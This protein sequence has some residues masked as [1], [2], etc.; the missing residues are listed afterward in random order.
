MAVKDVLSSEQLKNYYDAADN[1]SLIPGW[2]GGGHD[3]PPEIE[4]YLWRWSEVEP[5]VLKSG[6]V[7]TPDRDVERRTMRLATPGLQRGTTHTLVAALQLLLPGECAP[8][9]RHTPT[10]IRWILTGEGAYTT[11]EG[12]KCVREP[13]DLILTPSWTWHDHTDDGNSPMI[14]LDGLDV[15]LVQYLKAAFWEQFPEDT[16]PVT[17]VGDSVRKYASGSFRP[18]WE[19]VD[20]PYSPL[21]HYKWARTYEALQDLAE[22]NSSPFDDVAIEYSDPATGGPVL[23][24]MTCWIQMVRAGVHTK[25]H[26]HTASKVYQ[27]FRGQG[28]SVIDGKRFDWNQGDFF[29][30]PSWAWHEHVNES[31]EEA[32]LFSIQDT[33]V[34]KAMNLY[35]EE[36]Y[37]ENA[38]VQ[39]VTGHFGDSNS[40]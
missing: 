8:S 1:I 29:V 25:A 9:H 21:L 19:E 35:R 15:P 26:R 6:E 33:P 3:A 39:T 34:M 37:L 13:G 40:R 12:D 22:L 38:G 20:L 11:V 18:A 31:G 14:W 5:M 16:Q 30:V 28:Y 23:K 32:I 24:T 10:A 27:V 17:G 7:V 2:V 36:P 4:P